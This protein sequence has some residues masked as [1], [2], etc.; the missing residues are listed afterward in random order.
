MLLYNA[1][2]TIGERTARI[3]SLVL[4]LWGIVQSVFG[5]IGY[6]R[7]YAIIPP[8]FFMFG[9]LPVMLVI[10]IVLLLPFTRQ[11]IVRINI[12][13]LTWIHIIRIPV[14]FSLF[15]LF[16]VKLVPEQMTFEGINFDILS[17]LT[18][19]FVIFYGIR[20]R[21]VNRIFLLW[22]NITCLVLLFSIVVVAILSAPFPFQKIGA[23]QPNVAIFYFPFV[24]LPT[25]VVPIVLFA[26]LAAIIR[27]SSRR[28]KAS[29]E[30]R[31]YN[32]TI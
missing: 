29:Y 16:L 19:P 32:A 25:L 23:L 22:W 2:K 13:K 8:T 12:E 4:I 6:Y 17:G 20:K 7:H 27:L 10:A 9:I 11:K 5:Y 26:Q 28:K 1:L 15:W 31:T 14:E 30:R 24:L 18:A 3:V 21:K